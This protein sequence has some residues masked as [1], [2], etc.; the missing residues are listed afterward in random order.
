MITIII[1]VKYV[2]RI[3]YLE[4]VFLVAIPVIPTIIFT[5]F[6]ELEAIECEF[7]TPP[8]SPTS[9]VKNS[10][11]EE[12]TELIKLMVSMDETH[13]ANV[14]QQAPFQEGLILVTQKTIKIHLQFQSEYNWITSEEKKKEEYI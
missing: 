11:R 12:H 6:E 2:L 13:R 8:S 5:K 9:S 4:F 14:H 3:F 1:L 10:L 7:V